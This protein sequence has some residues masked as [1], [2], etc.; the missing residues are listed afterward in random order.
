MYLK[1]G[2]FKRGKKMLFWLIWHLRYITDNVSGRLAVDNND[3][4]FYNR[5]PRH[6]IYCLPE[7]FS[8]D[9]LILTLSSGTNNVYRGCDH[10]CYSLDGLNPQQ[11]NIK[12]SQGNWSRSAWGRAHIEGGLSR[13]YQILLARRNVKKKRI[14]RPH[15]KCFKKGRHQY[16]VDTI[17]SNILKFGVLPKIRI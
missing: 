15:K 1:W 4:G 5:R 13:Y 12:G 3:R 9:H 2:S 6:R 14:L 7:P 11:T 16:Q 17:N 8:Y 10:Q